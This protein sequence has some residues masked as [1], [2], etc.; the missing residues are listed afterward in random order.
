MADGYPSP[1]TDPR[2]DRGIDRVQNSRLTVLMAF[3][4]AGR[5]MFQRGPMLGWVHEWYEDHW[6]YSGAP[7]MTVDSTPL[8]AATFPWDDCVWANDEWSSLG[9]ALLAP[10]GL[11]W[12]RVP[13]RFRDRRGRFVRQ[14]E[15]RRRGLTCEASW[16]AEMAERVKAKAA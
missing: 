15:E 14:H 13:H 8:T 5:L 3:V 4:F 2:D 6:G 16:R 10:D 11:V 7:Y 1:H 9:W 12:Q